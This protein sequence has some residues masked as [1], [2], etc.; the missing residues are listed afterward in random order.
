VP[1]DNSATSAAIAGFVVAMV[2]AT[3]AMIAAVRMDIVI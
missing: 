1:S 2:S 3:P